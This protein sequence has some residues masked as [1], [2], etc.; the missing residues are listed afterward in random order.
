MTEA[1]AQRFDALF[2]EMVLAALTTPGDADPGLRRWAFERAVR[3]GGGPAGGEARSSPVEGSPGLQRFIT[4][5]AR[6]AYRIAD[7]DVEVLLASGYSEDALLEL[8]VSAAVGAGRLERGVD[9]I[10]QAT[11]DP[12][13]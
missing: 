9:V 3:A 12:A 11:G 8:I 7:R 1:T 5:V 13:R 2:D 6:S 10:R 4:E